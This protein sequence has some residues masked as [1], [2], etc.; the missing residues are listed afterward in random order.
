[1]AR[2]TDLSVR[3][4]LVARWQVQQPFWREKNPDIK[5]G[6]ADPMGSAL[7]EHYKMAI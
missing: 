4:A 1:M 3:L 7:F 6:I 5:I 2:L